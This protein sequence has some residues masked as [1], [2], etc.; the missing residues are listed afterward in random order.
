MAISPGTILELMKRAVSADEEARLDDLEDEIDLHLQLNYTPED[1]VPYILPADLSNPGIRE[2][3]RRY[4]E[5][6]WFVLTFRSSIDSA[7]ILYFSFKKN[8]PPSNPD[9]PRRIRG[10]H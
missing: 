10:L 5:A 1:S 2:M 8:S 9:G 3:M 7:V 4:R 6:G